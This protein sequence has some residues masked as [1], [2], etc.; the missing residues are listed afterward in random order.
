MNQLSK[1]ICFEFM[2]KWSCFLFLGLFSFAV[3]AQA[4]Y[5]NSI[6]QTSLAVKG[7]VSITG[8]NFPTNT[9]NLSV[10]FGAAQGTVVAATLT[11]NFMEVTVPAGATLDNVTVTNTQSGLTAFSNEVF[12]LSFGGNNYDVN[13]F[14]AQVST[15]TGGVGTHDICICDFNNDGLN[16]V[17][18]TNQ[19]TQNSGI[20]VF[21]NN[22]TTAA[23]NFT[24]NDLNV[25]LETFNNTCGDIDGDGLADLVV[26]QGG[27]GSNRFFVFR[28]TSSG[29]NVSFANFIEI[30]SPT[31]GT[32][33]IRNPKRISI[34]D[35]DL[36][37]KPELIVSNDANNQID[38][39]KNTST[40]GSI[41][42]ES[43]TVPTQI[44]ITNASKTLGLDV[45]DLNQDGLPDIAVNEDQGARLYI[46]QNASQPGTISF[47]D[48]KEFTVSANTRNLRIGD[49]DGDGFNDVALTHNTFNA[50]NVLRNTT[51]SAG[52][53]IN[54]AAATIITGVTSPWGLDL[55]DIDG[56]GDLDIVA[57]SINTATRAVYVLLN[58]TTTSL[59]FT[60]NS[61]STSQNSRNIKIADMNGDGK[62]D[63]AFTH[64]VSLNENGELSVIV[65]R[66]CVVPSI[67]PS[68]DIVVC[69]GLTARL[70]ATGAVGA[71]YRW[72]MA[73]LNTTNFAAVSTTND[74][75]LVVN[76]Q[77][78]YRVV[79][80]SDGNTC[81]NPSANSVN[82][83]IN[84]AQFI[85]TPTASDNDG[86]NVVCPGGANTVQLSA[87]TTDSGVQY[88]WTGPG[89]FTSTLQNP[90][91]TDLTPEK[92]GQYTV[93]TSKNNC[94]SDPSST[95][96][97]IES[98]P[99]IAVNNSGLDTFC[100]GST[101][102]LSVTD[103]GSAYTYKWKKDG[104][105]ISGATT[106]SLTVSESGAYSAVI[107]SASSTCFQ[108]SPAR[109]IQT[110]AVPTAAFTTSVSDICVNL[111]V[112]FDASGTTFDN[113]QPISYTWDFGDG[114]NGTGQT[115]SHTYASSGAMQPTL[116]VA[117]VNVTSCA[118]SNANATVNVQDPPVVNITTENGETQKCPDAAL[119]LNIDNGFTNIVWS[120]GATENFIDVVDPGTYTVDAVNSVG[121]AFTS[122][123]LSIINIP[124]SGISITSTSHTITTGQINLEPDDQSIS[125]TV[126][127]ATAPTWQPTDVINDNTATTITVIPQDIRTEVTV[128]ATD[129]NGCAS[130]DT[131]LIVNDNVRA[132]KVFSPNGDGI[133]DECWEITNARGDSFAQ[134]TVFIFD[135]K[136]KNLLRSNGPFPLDCVWDGTYNG[137]QLPEGIYYFAL[138]CENDA[139]SQS[140]TILLAR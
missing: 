74:N 107:T 81:A 92:S 119:R 80:L 14:D 51:G 19:Q 131:V 93:T 113:S 31:D 86:G 44:T 2:A 71:S 10:K 133:G 30:I 58:T 122:N 75:F 64:R 91:L 137:T 104:S 110:I 85:A 56:D 134:C 72:E 111:Q 8:L 114:N 39:Y 106:T 46:L 109:N 67:T 118:S 117:Y 37:G 50:V 83:E 126:E 138:K 115:T 57:T 140:G 77:G 35:L 90:E 24:K 65:N 61:I 29:G 121:C 96:V 28:N 55:G 135:S 87:T 5:I 101:I 125:L 99:T 36:D 102:G 22:S 26:S 7:T 78:T 88:M 41:T 17:V 108:E 68:D 20:N 49:F 120:T 97:V 76:T 38:I 59:S 21:T 15:A 103:F 95:T 6:D 54:F 84:N 139:F 3:S 105:D 32:G 9:A 62:P 129:L 47:L 43:T 124:N 4:P 82:F 40:P 63:L 45:K 33:N 136:G 94:T 70:E 48:A 130:A 52:G 112:D 34:Q 11:A 16:D 123:P 79:L 12:R 89:G 128:A 53:E 116:T 23:I 42:F 132:K 127:N 60:V 98:L 25:S 100:L 69:S 13:K 1:Y 73:P 18:T 27:G 66:H